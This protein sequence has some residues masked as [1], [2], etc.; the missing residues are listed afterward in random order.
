MDSRLRVSP[1]QDPKKRLRNRHRRF[2][3]FVF[4]L[5]WKNRDLMWANGRSS[6]IFG[7]DTLATRFSFTYVPLAVVFASSSVLKCRHAPAFYY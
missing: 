4:V 6:F 5:V 7:T 2:R 3:R 1:L